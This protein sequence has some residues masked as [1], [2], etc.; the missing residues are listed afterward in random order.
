MAEYGISKKER[1]EN[2]KR[3]QK[4]KTVEG[5]QKKQ[6]AG[7]H[8]MHRDDMVEFHI[9]RGKLQTMT[10]QKFYSCFP[11]Q[12]YHGIQDSKWAEYLDKN[13]KAGKEFRAKYA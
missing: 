2:L 7:I 11:S 4:P 13:D 10:V 6:K 12:P 9:G 8:W 3:N 5:I 1:K